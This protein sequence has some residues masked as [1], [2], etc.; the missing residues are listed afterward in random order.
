M[1]VWTESYHQECRAD[2]EDTGTVHKERASRR[3]DRASK[4]R[5]ILLLLL[6]L[7]SR[8]GYA[9]VEGDRHRDGSRVFPA[10]QVRIGLE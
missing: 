8:W 10:W 6:L 7:P 4:G 3:T 5:E 9:Q 1:T 2:T